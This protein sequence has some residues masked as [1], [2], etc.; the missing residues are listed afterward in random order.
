VNDILK[1][2]VRSHRDYIEA[3]RLMD[4]GA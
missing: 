4:E 2:S 3:F 1:E